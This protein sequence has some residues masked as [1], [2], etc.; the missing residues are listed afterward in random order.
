MIEKKADG[1]VE[2]DCSCV[3]RQASSPAIKGEASERMQVSCLACFWSLE[4]SHWELFPDIS[5]G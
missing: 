4:W 1:T 5:D 3:L 2:K